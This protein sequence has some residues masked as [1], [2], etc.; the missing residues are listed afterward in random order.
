MG[1]FSNDSSTES[2]VELFSSRVMPITVAPVVL[3]FFAAWDKPAA[4][5][6][7]SVAL[8]LISSSSLLFFWTCEEVDLNS[9]DV[10]QYSQFNYKNK[11]LNKLWNMGATCRKI[12][13]EDV[14]LLS[15]CVTAKLIHRKWAKVCSK[16]TTITEICDRNEY[17]AW[18]AQ[19]VPPKRIHYVTFGQKMII[20]NTQYHVYHIMNYM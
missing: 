5:S 2:A 1:V 15:N 11:L 10:Q 20:W 14:L 7:P 6:A 19:N 18:T 13:A 17:W 16:T 8:V 9:E 3:L 4:V 12:Y